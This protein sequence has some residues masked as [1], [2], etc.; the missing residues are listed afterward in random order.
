MT[1]YALFKEYP[2]MEDGWHET[3]IGIFSERELALKALEK[4]LEKKGTE[5]HLFNI[6]EFELD[7]LESE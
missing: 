6:E 1:L 7:E 3:L 5:R 4:C 2:D